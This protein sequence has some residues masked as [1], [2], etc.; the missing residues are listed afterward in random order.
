MRGEGTAQQA[1]FSSGSPEARVPATHPL[2]TITAKADTGLATRER[3]L[4]TMSSQTGRPSI[5]PERL[6]K[7]EG[8]IAL[9]S[10][11]SHRLFCEELHDNI[12]CRWLLAM[13]L[14]EPG[15]DHSPFS[16]NRERLL[17]YEVAQRCCDAVVTAARRE[18]LL[19]DEPLTVEGPLI[20]AWAS[21]KSVKPQAAPA[22][23]PPP[24]D[25]GN[26]PGDWHGEQRTTATPQRTTD[27]EARLA[28]KGQ[29]QEATRGCSGQVWRENRPGRWGDLQM[30]PATGT[31]EREAALARL[32]RQ[33][34]RGIRPRPLGAEQ[35]EHGRD[36]ARR[37][38]PRRI[39]PH[40]ARVA[41]GSSL[42][43]RAARRASEGSR[44]R[45]RRPLSSEPLT[46]GFGSAGCRCRCWPRDPQNG[47]AV[48]CVSLSR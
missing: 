19:S 23:T 24:D 34:R 35:G 17:Q 29:G 37:L 27:P 18:G 38:R 2:R 11:R 28:R 32:R 8:L 1:M 31:A 45:R 5:P 47:E 16:Q 4:A 14:D 7:S 21:L 25:P 15:F 6:R 26:P 12:L 3:P 43:A 36:C 39:R 30:A 46:T 13:S 33:A 9:F 44:A 10:I 42:G 41:G 20:E 48:C 40:L 22:V